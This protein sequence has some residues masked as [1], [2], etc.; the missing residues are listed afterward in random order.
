MRGVNFYVSFVAVLKQ[1]HSREICIFLTLRMSHHSFFLKK[2][3]IMRGK[4]FFEKS[5]EKV[6]IPGF[7]SAKKFQ[8]LF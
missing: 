7:F 8:A 3:S 5:K 6:N 2:F 1:F 4:T